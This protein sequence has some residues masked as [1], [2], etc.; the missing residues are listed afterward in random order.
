MAVHGSLDTMHGLLIHLK[1]EETWSLSLPLL[2]M[3]H[4]TLYAA[5]SVPSTLTRLYLEQLKAHNFFTCFH[6]RP[7]THLNVSLFIQT[8]LLHMTCMCFSKSSRIDR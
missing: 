5:S 3:H 4:A 6:Y 8:V 7:P 2:C 1:L